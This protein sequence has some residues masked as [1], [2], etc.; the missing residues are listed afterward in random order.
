MKKTILDI[1]CGS[2]MFWF[3]K[4]NPRVVFCDR[5][6]EQ[7]T[8]NDR[9]AKSGQRDLVIKPDIISDFRN[10]P[11]SSNFFS[12]V[13]FD[14]PH[15][16]SVGNNSWLRKKYGRLEGEWQHMLRDGFL[17]CFRVLKKDGT[18]IFKWAAVEFPLLDILKLTSVPPLF[19]HKSG[20]HNLTHW[21]AFTK[22]E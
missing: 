22:P 21:V 16:E 12:L 14:P 17:E 7:H 5:R 13:V 1:C 8:L 6:A 11:F 20:K 4:N 15:Y 2:K 9:T 3:E 10:L 18:L 19:G